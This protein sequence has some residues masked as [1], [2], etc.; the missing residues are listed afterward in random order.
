[1][2][3]RYIINKPSATVTINGVAQGQAITSFWCTSDDVLELEFNHRKL[4]ESHDI[5]VQA[6]RYIA[7]LY[8]DSKPSYYQVAY[9]A[10]AMRSEAATALERIGEVMR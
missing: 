8:D 6:L 7:S 10:Y 1:M 5:A 4:T 3:Q 2:I 9:D